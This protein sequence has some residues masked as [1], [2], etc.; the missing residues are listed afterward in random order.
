MKESIAYLIDL[1]ALRTREHWKPVGPS[2]FTNS[3]EMRTPDAGG[4]HD[5]PTRLFGSVAGQIRPQ[6]ATDF[7]FIAAL[8][9]NADELLAAY[10]FAVARGFTS[11]QDQGEKK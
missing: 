3:W 7:A 6:D 4:K 1:N 10:E 5:W 11:S 9:N 8:A 2:G